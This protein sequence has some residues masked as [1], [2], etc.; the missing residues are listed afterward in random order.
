M[1]NHSLRKKLLLWL[2]P[3]LLCLIVIDSSILYRVAMH[4]QRKAFDHALN[5]AAYDISQ[6]I[7]EPKDAG[8]RFQLRPEVRKIILSDQYDQMYY[9]IIDASG[10]VIG[11]DEAL[12][13][14]PSPHHDKTTSYFSLGKIGQNLIRVAVIPARVKTEA[15][16]QDVAIQVAETLNKRNR[17]AEQILIGIVVP[18]V[19]LLLT[20]AALLWFGIGRG[21]MPLW[22]LHSAVSRRSPRDLSPVQ[23]TDIPNEVRALVDSVNFLMK[24]LQHALESQNQFI[25]DAAHQLRTP[26]AGMLAQVELAQ[27]ETDP[28]ELQACLTRVASSM[29]RLA[30]LVNQLLRLAHSQPEAIHNIAFSA[31]DLSGL[32][33]QTTMEMV[34]TAYQKDIDLGFEGVPD[35][36]IIEGEPQRLKE[37]LFNLIDNAI[38]YTQHGGK[39]TVSISHRGNRARLSVED[40]GQGIPL[41]ERGKVFERFHRVIGTEQE[42]SG[43]GLA[44]VMEIAQIHHAAVAMEV[45]ESGA[46]T[47][48]SVLFD[49]FYPN[50]DS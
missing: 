40:N 31:I 49:L 38:R 24:Q 34:P 48:V 37:L 47:R 21:L 9:S 28:V 5:D 25:A 33:Q 22:D 23:L 7:N 35:K 19:I 46:G 36:L 13:P 16:S 8:K 1:T 20:A 29:E 6:L 43:L 32:A 2:L 41:E 50:A 26:L 11:G 17:L 14:I 44:I 3:P 45:P 39:V 42:G 27:R 10:N 18:Q 15:G 12:K 30:H 4:F